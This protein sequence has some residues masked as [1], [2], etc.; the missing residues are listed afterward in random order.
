A[1]VFGCQHD[2]QT[3]FPPGLSPLE[4]DPAPAP[5]ATP[6]DPYPETIDV[7]AGNDGKSDYVHATG[8]VHASIEDVWAA[9]KDPAV[10]VDRHHVD[11]WSSTPNVETGYDVSFRT[12]YTVNNLV[13]VQFSLTWR[14]G[15]V[16]GT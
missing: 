2:V 10:V 14:E 6:T 5:A 16:E 7:Q 13:T 3:S 8:Y 1:L 11:A 12:D 9:M 15:V 4:D